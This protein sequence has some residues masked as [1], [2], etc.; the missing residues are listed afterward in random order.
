MKQDHPSFHFADQC[1]GENKRPS[2]TLIKINLMDSY[3]PINVHLVGI[4]YICTHGPCMLGCIDACAG[5]YVQESDDG[6]GRSNDDDAE[7]R[8]FLKNFTKFFR[9]PVTSNLYTYA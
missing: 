9:F 7:M 5:A 3:V 8:A 4:I 6:A 1:K 2:H